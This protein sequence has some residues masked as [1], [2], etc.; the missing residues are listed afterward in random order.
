MH[1]GKKNTIK[2]ATRFRAYICACPNDPTTHDDLRAPR[3]YEPRVHGV[4][5]GIV[6]RPHRPALAARVPEAR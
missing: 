2:I 1:V 5:D 4:L 3:D 6:I